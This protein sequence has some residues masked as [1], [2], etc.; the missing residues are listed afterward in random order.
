MNTTSR[1][2]VE[3]CNEVL[4]RVSSSIG[5]ADVGAGG[6][7]KEPWS[8]M[9]KEK[10]LKFDFEPTDTT[11]S[12]LPLCIS[13]RK[14][15]FP[16]YVA[17]DERGSSLHEPSHDFA[18]RLGKPEYYTKKTIEVECTTLDEHFAGKYGQIDL[19]DVNVEGHDFQ[20]LQGAE[21]LLED[22]F[23]KLIKVEFELTEVWRGQGWFSDIDEYLR[24]KGFDLATIDLEYARPAKVQHIFHRG[25]VL[26]GK[27]FY[28]PSLASWQ[29]HLTKYSSLDSVLK[30]VALYALTDIPGRAFDL[31]DLAATKG[32]LKEAEAKQLKDKIT[33]IFAKARIDALAD[34]WKK[35][36][37]FVKNALGGR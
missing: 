30:A 36:K 19:M 10:V 7:L 18:D 6:P 31:L 33:R 23:V 9:P 25:E 4:S 28:V 22:G 2:K 12:G 37:R 15:V 26:W 24:K 29:E 11:A 34:E 13:N 1:R 32:C 3:F 20:S 16:F 8:F 17:I 35:A 14:G 21:K 5:F 27:A